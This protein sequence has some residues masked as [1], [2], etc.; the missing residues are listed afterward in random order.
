MYFIEFLS[1]FMCLAIY[2]GSLITDNRSVLSIVEISKNGLKNLFTLWCLC[3]WGGG[4]GKEEIDGVEGRE[5]IPIKLRRH[6][7]FVDSKIIKLC[8]NTKCSV[9]IIKTTIFNCIYYETMHI[10]RLR[11]R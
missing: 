11:R 3:H 7:E 9:T 2:N 1:L 6:I 4:K 5:V 8:L 10:E